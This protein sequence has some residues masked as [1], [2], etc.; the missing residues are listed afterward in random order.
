M[1]ILRNVLLVMGCAMIMV[2]PGK[3][4][5]QDSENGVVRTVSDDVSVSLSGTLQPRVTYTSDDDTDRVGFGLRR[6]RLRVSADI[7]DRLGVFLQMEGSGG[8]ASWLDVRGEYY[9]NDNLTMRTGRFVGTQPRAYARTSHAAIDAIDRPAISDMWARMTIGADGRDYGLEALYS[10]PE[11][12]VRGFLHNGYNRLNFG[13]GISHDPVHG[14]IE[15]DGM[16]FSASATHWPSGRDELELGAYASINTSQSVLTD[17]SSN[18][19]INFPGVATGRNYFSYSANAYYGPLPGSQ[20]YRLKAD[21]IGISYEDVEPFGNQ[22]YVGTSLLGAILVAPHVELY[23][24]GEFWHNDRGDHDGMS[25]VFATLGGSYSFS[26]LQ[27]G[28][29]V[30]NRLMLAYN[31][32]TQE[33]DSIDFDDVAHVLMM[34]MQFYF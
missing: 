22:N 28:P 21:L 23:A 19:N 30:H 12:E 11:W 7:S 14:G 6:L 31:F 9:V 17:P 2:L 4:Y 20:P 5:G 29:F 1:M 16:A 8:A 24:M 3:G 33:S 10:S 13:R 26:A 34:Q 15:T 18:A 25:Q 27:G 32:R